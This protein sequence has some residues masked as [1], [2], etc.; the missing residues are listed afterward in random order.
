V[1][2]AAIAILGRIGGAQAVEPLRVALGDQ[3]EEV[4]KAAAEALDQLGR[5]PNRGNA[6]QA[7]W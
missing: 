2:R 3:R 1:R 6:E 5:Q 4:R 7:I